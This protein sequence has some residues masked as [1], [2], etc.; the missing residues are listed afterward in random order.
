MEFAAG[1]KADRI[2]PFDIKSG[3]RPKYLIDWGRTLDA[4]IKDTESGTGNDM[5]SSRFHATL[6]EMAAK[7]A[8]SVGEKRIVISGGCFQ[9]ALLIREFRRVL[10]GR[11]FEVYMHQRVPPN[12]GGIS[13]GQVIATAEAM[14]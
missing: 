4:I 11:G 14:K 6:A 9:N 7:I 1:E 10:G 3:G 2:Y 13:L 5:I 8:E 12:D